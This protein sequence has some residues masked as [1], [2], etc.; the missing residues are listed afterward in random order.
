[1]FGQRWGKVG[2]MDMT[3]SVIAHL[4]GGNVHLHNFL[5]GKLTKSIKSVRH[6]HTFSRR[7]SIF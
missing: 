3:K 1:M 5:E 7:N 2:I 4:A 6:V